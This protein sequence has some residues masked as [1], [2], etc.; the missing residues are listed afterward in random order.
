MSKYKS[1][2]QIDAINEK[3]A[4]RKALKQ[5]CKDCIDEQDCVVP[6]LLGIIETSCDGNCNDCI[7]D[8]CVLSK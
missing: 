7:D 2:I 8:I 6:R 5:F 3:I 1:K 4:N